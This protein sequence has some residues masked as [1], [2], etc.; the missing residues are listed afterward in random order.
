MVIH[1]ITGLTPGQVPALEEGETVKHT[2]KAMKLYLEDV[3]EG[4]GTLFV[5]EK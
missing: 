4:T 3:C 1:C 2:A 5:T